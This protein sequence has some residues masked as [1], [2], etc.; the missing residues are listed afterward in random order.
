MP[1][2]FTFHHWLPDTFTHFPILY[3]F[4]GI[5]RENKKLSAQNQISDLY[6][7]SMPTFLLSIPKDKIWITSNVVHPSEF[8]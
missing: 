4:L 7:Y 2:K 6:P 1:Y 3:F 5:L 8:T